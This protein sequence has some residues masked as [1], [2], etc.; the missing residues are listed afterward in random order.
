MQHRRKSRLFAVVHFTFKNDDANDVN[1][2]DDDDGDGGRFYIAL[3][4]ILE[5]PN[6][7]RFYR[8]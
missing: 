6:S 7:L 4:S 1:D 3:L 5:R 8:M 2:D